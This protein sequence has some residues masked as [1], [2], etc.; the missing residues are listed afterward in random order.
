MPDKDINTAR[1]RCCVGLAYLEMGKLKQA[2]QA[3]LSVNLAMLLSFPGGGGSSTSPVPPHVPPPMITS[4]TA[5]A[6]SGSGTAAVSSSSS[7]SQQQPIAPFADV[8][9]AND[10]AVYAALCALATFDRTELK[11]DV[12]DSADAR[13]FLELGKIGEIFMCVCEW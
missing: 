9:A 3:L 5:G 1:L 4:K 12:L 8:I 13:A 11:R 7:S 2:A 10:V 6:A